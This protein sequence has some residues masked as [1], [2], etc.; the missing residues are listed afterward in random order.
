MKILCYSSCYGIIFKEMIY[1]QEQIIFDTILWYE[2]QSEIDYKTYSDYDIILCEYVP[3][4]FEFKS[5]DNFLNNIRKYNP[6]AKIIIYPLIVMYIFPFH[7]HNFGFMPN[8]AIDMLIEKGKTHDEICELYE[9]NEIKFNPKMNYII[10]LNRL[11]EVEKQCNIIISDYIEQNI[12]KE[13]LFIDTLFPSQQLFN[14]I[15]T[16]I[17]EKINNPILKFRDY[18]CNK[19]LHYMRYMGTPPFKAEY[20]YLFH[21]MNFYY[22]QEMINDLEL[23]YI[24][25]ST[26]GFYDYYYYKLKEYFKI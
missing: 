25:T 18:D 16:K 8:S 26:P 11:K 4:K 9:K 23:T 20:I 1:S 12:H 2:L 22:T 19:E 6:N 14:S 15:I 10:S 7:K 3:S 21:K 24:Q 17:L 5:S 13:L